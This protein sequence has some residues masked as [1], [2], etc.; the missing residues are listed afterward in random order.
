MPQMNENAAE[1]LE[2]V[3]ASELARVLDLQS[4]WE[5]MRADGGDSTAQLQALQKAFEAYRLRLAE[6]TAR[7]RSEQTPDLSPERAKPARGMV[8][9]GTGSLPARWGWRRMSKPGRDES[10]SDGRPNRGASEG[11]TGRSGHPADRHARCNQAIR[12]GHRVVRSPGRPP[13]QAAAQRRRPFTRWAALRHS[14]DGPS[15]PI[16]LHVF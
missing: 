11:G 13:T 7:H 1:R 2:P 8:Q 15:S 6:Y 10:V 3:R 9:D 16:P 4:R 14:A 5:N 12:R